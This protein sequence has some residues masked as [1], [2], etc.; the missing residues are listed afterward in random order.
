M[1]LAD[2]G[3]DDWFQQKQ[4]ELDKHGHNIARVTA[5]NKD[6]YLVMNETGEALAELTGGFLFAVESSTEFPVVGDWAFVEYYN[7]GTLAIIHDLFPRK[8]MLRRKTAGKKVDYQMIAANIDVAL[9]IQS[10]DFNFNLRR[11]ERYLVMASEGQIE[12]VILMSKSDLVSQQKLEQIISE[13]RNAMVNC[14]IIAYSSLSGL[15]LD[16]IQLLLEHGK[17]YCLLGSSG[18]G[19][20]TLLNR[21]VGREAFET[22]L[23]R[24]KDGKGRHTTTRRQLVVID[25]GAMLID[26]PGMRELGN[27]DAGTGINEMFSDINSL[28]AGCRFNDC[29]HTGEDGCSVLQ[30][31]QDGKLDKARYQSYLKLLKESEHYQMSYAEKR[32]KDRKFG[33]FIKTAG[34]E[35]KRIKKK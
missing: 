30:A 16:Q 19:K 2:I 17:T 23:V 29:T 7:S 5:V 1:E 20:T 21:L 13:I 12:P 34:K 25:R 14:Q 6:N 27:I 35:I 26:T 18:V 9:I 3:F 15:G 32:K 33:Q 10:Y 4:K 31:V 11:M 28:T 8:T 22:N 24:D